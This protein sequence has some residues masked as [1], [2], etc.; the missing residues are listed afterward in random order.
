METMKH[1]RINKSPKDASNWWADATIHIL[2]S[3]QDGRWPCYLAHVKQL[4]LRKRKAAPKSLGLVADVLRGALMV[5]D[6]GQHPELSSRGLLRSINKLTEH[7]RSD[8]VTQTRLLQWNG[9]QNPFKTTLQSGLSTDKSK[10]TVQ[11]TKNI[12]SSPGQHEWQLTF[13]INYKFSFISCLHSS[14]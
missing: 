7:T 9:I 3:L 14:K 5:G 8:Q 6:T 4:T 12:K 13:E 11:T 1:K 2:L 10:A